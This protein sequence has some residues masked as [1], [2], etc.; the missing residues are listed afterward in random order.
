MDLCH[1][2]HPYRRPPRSLGKAGTRGGVGHGRLGHI[3]CRKDHPLARQKRLTVA[4]L[5]PYNWVFPTR[6]LPRRAT[7]E[8]VVTAWDLSRQVQIETNSLGTL[9]ADLVASDHISLLPRAYD[10]HSD[11]LA[12][13]PIPVPHPRRVVGLTMRRGWLPTDFQADF[14][15]LMKA[16][17]S[18]A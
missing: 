4:D 14:I 13:L 6:G 18:E 16:T 17:S 8:S 15:A 2:C 7:L 5:K 3:V 10:D 12:M 1:V 9:I 11:V